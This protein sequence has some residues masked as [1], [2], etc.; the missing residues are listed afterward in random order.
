MLRT[1]HLGPGRA[2]CGASKA[3]GADFKGQ[4]EIERD[5]RTLSLSKRRD[6][7]PALFNAVKRKESPELELHLCVWYVFVRR[8]L[9]DTTRIFIVHF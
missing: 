2:R 1:F 5:K 4:R 8:F 7:K 9:L 6:L 3:A